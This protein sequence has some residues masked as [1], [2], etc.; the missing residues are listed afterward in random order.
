MN[1]NEKDTAGNQGGGVAASAIHEATNGDAC[2]DSV[3]RENA[4]AVQKEYNNTAND[5]ET[6]QTQAGWD[7]VPQGNTVPSPRGRRRLSLA[8]KALTVG[9]SAIASGGLSVLIA[10][11][12]FFV[13]A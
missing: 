3:Q 9:L 8:E 2:G 5:G 4:E 12:A 6:L 7:S 11:F 1:E 10:P 13:A